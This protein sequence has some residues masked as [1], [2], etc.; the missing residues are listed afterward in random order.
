M[1]LGKWVHG[2]L[3]QPSRQNEGSLVTVDEEESAA[4]CNLLHY[5]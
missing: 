4:V 1:R 2:V 5:E 3:K